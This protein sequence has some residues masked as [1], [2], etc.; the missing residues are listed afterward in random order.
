MRQDSASMIE[1][2]EVNVLKSSGW[3]GCKIRGF[4]MIRNID[5]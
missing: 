5:K 4:E 3:L 2:S 1:A